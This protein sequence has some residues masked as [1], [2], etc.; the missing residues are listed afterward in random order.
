MTWQVARESGSRRFQGSR[1]I[2]RRGV[3]DRTVSPNAPHTKPAGVRTSLDKSHPL[4]RGSESLPKP[5][6]HPRIAARFP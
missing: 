5:L 6:Q 1:C 2:D 4:F 3:H